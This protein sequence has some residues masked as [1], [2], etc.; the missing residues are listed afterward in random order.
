MQSFSKLLIISNLVK[1]DL[2]NHSPIILAI[3]HKKIMTKAQPCSTCRPCCF[4]IMKQTSKNG[5]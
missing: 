1:K 5:Y 2:F 4:R 3:P